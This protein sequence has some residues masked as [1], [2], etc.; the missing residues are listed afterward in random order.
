MALKKQK[1]PSTTMIIP[2]YRRP[3]SLKK[4]LKT[5]LKQTIQFDEIIIL[6][7]SDDELTKKMLKEFRG[8]L[9]IIYIKKKPER[10]GMTIST[11]MGIDI[12]KGDYIF[13][14]EDDML[15][16]AK[17]YVEKSLKFFEEHTNAV[18]I[19]WFPYTS[20]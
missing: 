13:L 7:D 6:D 5:Y 8:K 14:S 11:N 9:N 18:G 19:N 20:Q 4:V 2:T 15:L 1:R 16:T 12:A 10:R 3:E 17:D